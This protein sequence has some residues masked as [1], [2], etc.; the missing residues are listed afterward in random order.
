M[1]LLTS[2]R[3]PRLHGRQESLEVLQATLNRACRSG[4]QLLLISGEAGVGKTTLVQ[5][6]RPAVRQAQGF[7]ALGKCEHFR[8]DAVLRAPRQALQQLLIALLSRPEPQRMPLRRDLHQALGTAAAALLPLLPELKAL[9]GELPPARALELQE[10]SVRLRVLMLELLRQVLRHWRPL[11]LV[12]DDLQWADQSTLDLLAALQEG[13]E[14]GGLV[15]IGL[16]RPEPR[17]AD[18][19]LARWL[20]K[21]ADAPQPPL[22]LELRNLPAAELTAVVADMLDSD[23]AQVAD[24]SAS[25]HRCTDGNPFFAR[26]LVRALHREGLLR[27]APGGWHWDGASIARRVSGAEVEEIL[28]GQLGDLPPASRD[29]LVTLACLGSRTTLAQLA[30]V[31]GETPSDLQRR[32]LP[33]LEQ[34]VL[35]SHGPAAL[36]AGDPQ[37][38]V[39]F[40]HDRLLQ[41][42]A[43]LRDPAWRQRIQLTI[44][45]RLVGGGQRLEAAD[46]YT[47]AAAL[48]DQEPEQR[49]V[50]ELLLES[51]R[52]ALSA[53]G[54]ETADRQ[55]QVAFALLGEQPWRRVAAL[56]WPL[57]V[58]LHQVSYCR[59][60]Y[61]RADAHYADLRQR[62]ERPGQLLAPACIQV[63]S[64]S[65]R[66]RYREAV[67]LS[68]QL[69]AQLGIAVP[70]AENLQGELQRQLQAFVEAVGQGALEQLPA[71]SAEPAEASVVRL[72]NRL[73][74]AAFFCDPP[75]ACWLVL[76]SAHGWI[77]GDRDPARL[78][79]MACTLLASVAWRDD[80]RSGWLAAR[81]ALAAGEA[82]E[83]G[84]ETA[85]TR[86]VYALFNSHWCEPLEQ[87][88][89]Q[90]RRAH[91]QLLHGGEL[92]FA[93]YTFYTSQAALLE[94]APCLAEL[95]E[96]NRLAL[97][98]ARRTGNRHAEP[99]YAAFQQLIADLSGSP[100]T[101]RAADRELELAQTNPM[102]ACDSHVLRALAACLL[103]DGET[104]ERQARMASAL[105]PFITG[106]YPVVWIRVLE[107]FALLARRSRGDADPGGAER[108]EALQAWLAARAADS[109]H[110]FDHLVD[111]LAAERLS[112]EQRRSEALPLYERAMRGAIAHQRPWHAALTT[113]R[114]ARCYLALDLEQAGQRLLEQAHRLYGAWGA[115]RKQRLLEDEFPFLRGAGSLRP[116]GD[117][118]LEAIQRLGA[119]RTTAELAQTSAELIGRL[120]GATDVQ[121][122]VL[123]PDQEWELTGS[124]RPGGPL[125]RQSLAVASAAGLVAESALQLAIRQLLPVISPDAVRDGR[126][127]GDP[128]LR[129]LGVCSLLAV[130]LIV[131]NR[132]LAVAIVEHRGMRGV[133]APA[134][135]Q[136]VQLVCGQ[137]A[138]ALENS[139]IQ[140]SLQQQVEQRSAELRAAYE[141]EARNEEQRRRL[142]EQKLKT[143]LTAAA[144]VHEIQQPLSAILLNCRLASHSLEQLPAEQLPAGL[145]TS[146]GQ[147]SRDGD[148]VVSTMERIRMLLRNVETEHGP[149]DLC[150]SVDSALLFLKRD[151]ALQS[152]EP[153]LQGLD[154]PCQIHGDG[155][156][157]QIA[158][159]NLIRNALQAM[160]AQPPAS[161]RLRVQLCRQ[162][163]QLE[164]TVADSGPGFPDDFSGDTSWALL[165][166]TKATG[167]GIGLFL[168]E[169]AATNHRGQLCLGRS[170]SLG[171]AEVRIV[172]PLP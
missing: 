83:A 25:L 9:L 72:M 55:L 57:Q 100:L 88:L 30:R 162:A 85:R 24:L 77:D 163:E 71:I 38:D 39:G 69:L 118:L 7:Y 146:L 86:H 121:I 116:E 166:S 112:S 137:L 107:A 148:Q 101:A 147:L 124:F 49:L 132:P 90:A 46:H 110:N 144:V 172:L 70:G 125:P 92:E 152:L 91:E 10:R 37:A 94:T 171:G 5:G 78:Y 51:G 130:P 97:A 40:S 68:L 12:L 61:E 35:N 74:P 108:W 160:Q 29:L 54:F 56:A 67:E 63:M 103:G 87:G 47:R 158:V 126:F 156:Q 23:P 27:S 8:S 167:M 48:L 140:R 36:R 164:L 114:A 157:L 73:V 89:I 4:L 32:L 133:F 120:S 165:Q 169:T 65:N 104:L 168:A 58:A 145:R 76:R 11:V 14:L 59:A 50:A 159:V 102:A 99:A 84:V 131:Q 52:A 42:A 95:A 142:L 64:L 31:S 81:A 134:L 129:D 66:S 43:E 154:Q 111:L 128:H 75:L 115:D 3:P 33:P 119:L 17:S 153:Q 20:R 98:F 123:N 138:V 28:L 143:S 122:V 136:A 34:G 141:R 22:R 150:A 6:L 82:G 15:L 79:P 16:Y 170:A 105:E 41:A 139:L 60:D 21:A 80:Y 62:A 53:G 18:S 149:V 26:E 2:P 106:F 113:E 96:E 151:L 109:P 93:C 1:T 161:R 19:P 135:A 45:R 117:T 13:Q 155:A 44:A 127:R